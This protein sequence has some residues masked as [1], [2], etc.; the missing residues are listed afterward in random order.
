VL[1]ELT[2]YL[3]CAAAA[4]GGGLAIHFLRGP[5]VRR[6]PFLI[7][8]VH[9]VLGT[10]GLALLLL[11]LYRG[12]LPSTAGTTGFGPTPAAF[13]ALALL[14]GVAIAL[15][16]MRPPDFLVAFHAGLAV[17]GFV[18]LWTVVSLG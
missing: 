11:A 5:A 8:L 7:L 12:L 14:L 4:L 9:G 3:L 13:I 2:F 1:L 10:A 6:P 18:V 15:L 16:R 17:A